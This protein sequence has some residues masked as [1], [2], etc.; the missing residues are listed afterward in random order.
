MQ[1]TSRKL[2]LPSAGR[3]RCAL[4][5]WRRAEVARRPADR[6]AAA[7]AVQLCAVVRLVVAHAAG[8]QAKRW[9]RSSGSTRWAVCAAPATCAK[10]DSPSQQTT[11]LRSV[12]QTR[13]IRQRV[14]R[15]PHDRLA[16][17]YLA[18]KFNRHW[19]PM[20]SS[21]S[22]L[23][24]RRLTRERFVVRPAFPLA[25]ALWRRRTFVRARAR[26]LR[27]IIRSSHATRRERAKLRRR[28]L[29]SRALAQFAPT[30]RP[31]TGAASAQAPAS[32]TL[33]ERQQQ[34][35]VRS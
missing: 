28:P 18:T 19:R 4:R 8:N 12:G 16:C 24:V 6:S 22:R 2:C 5:Q 20:A 1:V 25:T 9:A 26:A 34:N 3:R 27:A 33:R 15:R 13:T 29:N 23:V 35:S 14:E 31:G 30:C 32:V 11:P 7:Q 17:C 21:F 10:A